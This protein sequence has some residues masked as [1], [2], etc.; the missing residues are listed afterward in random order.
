MPALGPFIYERGANPAVSEIQAEMLA[1]YHQIATGGPAWVAANGSSVLAT[2][3]GAMPSL[4]AGGSFLF[5]WFAW[6]YERPL[7]VLYVPLFTF[8][9]VEAIASRWHYLIDLPMGILLA[10]GCI[11]LAFRF[12]R[13]PNPAAAKTSAPALQ[14]GQIMVMDA[15]AR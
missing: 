9:C 15:K 5:L 11:A 4:H 1:I 14:L 10:R 12:D 2:G 7:L 8:I 13:L 6:R 3:L